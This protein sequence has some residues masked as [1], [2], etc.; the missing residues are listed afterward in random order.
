VTGNNSFGLFP[1]GKRLAELLGD[2]GSVVIAGKSGEKVL[3]AGARERLC[4]EL[5]KPRSRPLTHV[6]ILTGI[7][8]LRVN[9]SSDSV[10]AA[11]ETLFDVVYDHGARCMA[12]TLPPIG[13]EDTGYRSWTESRARVNSGLRS[14]AAA[15]AHGKGSLLLA[16]F[17]AAMARL[18]QSVQNS[19]YCD[20]L[21]FTEKGYGMLAEVVHAALDSGSNA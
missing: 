2:H 4:Q 13:P 3:P 19:L 14:L 20:G 5:S 18:P 15:E 9:A 21:H 12:V 7:N 1:Y 16:D 8:D 10:L 6:V 17:D 11:L